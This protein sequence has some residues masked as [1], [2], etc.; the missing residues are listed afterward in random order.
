MFF[1][2]I[3]S[4]DSKECFR[5]STRLT[6]SLSD[7]SIIAFKLKV[8]WVLQEWNLGD[9]YFLEIGDIVYVMRMFPFWYEITKWPEWITF[10]NWAWRANLLWKWIAW[11]VEY[12]ILS[13]FSNQAFLVHDD[14]EQSPLRRKQLEAYWT[15][16]A[17]ESITNYLTFLRRAVFSSFFVIKKMPSWIMDPEILQLSEKE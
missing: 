8:D 3:H 5:Y 4:S 9:A 7:E 12:F 14:E 15:A 17:W 16:Q 13:Q 2:V 11:A 10:K 6:R 1:E